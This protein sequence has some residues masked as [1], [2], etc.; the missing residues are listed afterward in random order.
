MSIAATVHQDLIADAPQFDADERRLTNAG[1]WQ[2]YLAQTNRPGSF[3]TDDL[4]QKAMMSPGHTLKIPAYNSK[5]VTIRTTRPIIIPADE[6]TSAYYTVQWTTFAFGFTMTPQQHFNNYMNYVR[7]WGAKYMS[8]AVKALKAI[9]DATVANL[10]AGK[11][12]VVNQ[13]TGDST[14]FDVNTVHETALAKLKDSYVLS[15]LGP[16]MASNDFYG[17]NLDVVGEQGLHGVLNM[18]EGFSGFNSENKTIQFLGKNFAFSNS[19]SN[20]TNKKA[21]GYAI[22]DNTVGVLTRMEPDSIL[23]TELKSGHEWGSM[24]MPETGIEWGTYYYEDVTDASALHSG[25]SHLTRTGLEAFDFAVDI[26]FVRKYNS[27]PATI[28]SNIMKF[29][30]ETA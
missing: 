17:L 19:V 13:L 21:T 26:A 24:F 11:T 4:K 23:G 1:A 10:E 20:A 28:P 7:D 8:G 29:D 30:L 15:Q 3:L 2:T 12:Q 5:D 18:M 14:S 9:E 16:M 25:T 22:G 27:D 6:N